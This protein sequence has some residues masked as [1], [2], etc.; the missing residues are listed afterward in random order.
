MNKVIINSPDTELT[1]YGKKGMK[2]GILN[3]KQKAILNKTKVRTTA[4][5]KNRL[6]DELEDDRKN[7]IDK[8]TNIRRFD[9]KTESINTASKKVNE[10]FYYSDNI[11]QK[12]IDQYTLDH[13]FFDGVYGFGNNCPSAA[14][15][16]EFRRRGYDVEAGVT[17]GASVEEIYQMFGKVGPATGDTIP[18]STIE[19]V[20]QKMR[21]MGPGARGF[22]ISKWVGNRGGHISSFEI[23]ANGQILYVD[24]Q[25]GTTSTTSYLEFTDSYEILRTD[26]LVIKPEMIN[27]WTR[28]DD[29][30]NPEEDIATN[31]ARKISTESRKQE[32]VRMLEVIKREN[33]KKAVKL[34]EKQKR[35]QEQTAKNKKEKVDLYYRMKIKTKDALLNRVDNKPITVSQV[36]KGKNWFDKIF[37][38]KR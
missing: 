10:G 15:S 28:S 16:Y 36:T 9:P 3:E 17:G 23:D 37:K 18:P 7:K 2:W 4:T 19:N 1:H 13:G 6:I 22:C 31:A 29:N 26:N 30:I 35:E 21:D 12:L 14:F 24:A 32:M 8:V 25:A 38:K 34:A 33:E 5:G 20:E 11:D 27:R